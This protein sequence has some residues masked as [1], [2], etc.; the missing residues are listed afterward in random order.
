[1]GNRFENAWNDVWTWI[2]TT[3]DEKYPPVFKIWGK[4]YFWDRTGTNV[5]GPYPTVKI[6]RQAFHAYNSTNA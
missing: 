3:L 1:M 5:V 6:A 2:I 4:W